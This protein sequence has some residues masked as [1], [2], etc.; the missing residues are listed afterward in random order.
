MMK[1]EKVKQRSDTH[2]LWFSTMDRSGNWRDNLELRRE[3]FHA[4][5]P[6]PGI[7][8]ITFVFNANVGNNSTNYPAISAAPSVTSNLRLYVT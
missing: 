3:V 2:R 1:S 7:L 5:R 8:T 4:M 6:F